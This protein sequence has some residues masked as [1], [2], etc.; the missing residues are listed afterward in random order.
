MRYI[1]FDSEQVIWISI[2]CF[3]QQSAFDQNKIRILRNSF[4]V[5]FVVIFRKMCNIASEAF[6]FQRDKL[7][8]IAIY[9]H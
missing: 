4:L 9:A 1:L 5:Q 8:I 7:S 2:M 6:L 3:A